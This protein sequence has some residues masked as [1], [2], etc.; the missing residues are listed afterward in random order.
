MEAAAQLNAVIGGKHPVH[1]LV[2][3]EKAILK[4]RAAATDL[5]RS[6]YRRRLTA[7]VRSTFY[8]SGREVC[9]G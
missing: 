2:G 9:S 8:Q 5:R 7:G 6:G 1:R 3:G 4:G